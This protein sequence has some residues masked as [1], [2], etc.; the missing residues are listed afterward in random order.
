MARHK[1]PSLAFYFAWAVARIVG[2]AAFVF[3][4]LLFLYAFFPV[5]ATPYMVWQAFHGY[6]WHQKWIPLARLPHTAAYAAIASEDGRFCQHHGVDWDAVQKVYDDWQ[7][8]GRLRGASTITMQVAKNVFLWQGAFDGPRKLLEVPL[9][10][11]IDYL[12]GK[13][14]IMEIYLNIAEFG[15]GVYGLEAAAEYHF[16]KHA[17]Q[18]T[19]Y[20][21]YRLVSILPAPLRWSPR[22]PSEWSRQRA[23]SLSARIRQLGPAISC[24]PRMK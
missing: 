14:R 4:L 6:G 17:R 24:L 18:L 12:W 13:P 16:H 19:P 3:V 22:N 15:P 9:A 20:E 10:Y 11:T 23:N 2:W 7:D 8:G 1:S 21:S 5:Y